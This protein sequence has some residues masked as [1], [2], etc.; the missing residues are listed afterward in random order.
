MAH[1][2]EILTAHPVIDGHN[3]LP[4]T[5][6]ESGAPPRDVDAYDLRRRTPGDTDLPRMRQGRVGAQFWSV[7]VPSTDDVKPLGLTR[8]Q[9]EQIDIALRIIE[10]YPEAMQLALTADDIERANRDG[11]IASLLGIEGAHTLENSLGTLRTYYRLGVRYMTL[12][13]YMNHDWA[14]SA[15]DARRHGG[16]TPF[17]KEVVRE[18]NR[19]GML[20]DLS[21]VSPDVM[22][23][24]LQ[25]S[26]APVIFSHSNALA[27]TDHPRNV[28]DDV[29]KRTG[30]GGGLVMV[31]FISM[32]SVTG[33]VHDRWRKGFARASAGAKPGDANF[34]AQY[35]LYTKQHPEPRATVAD[36][37]DHI[38][39][40][41]K[42]AGQDHVGIGSDFYGEG[43][44]MAAELEDTSSFPNLFAELVRRGWSDQALI[45]LARGNLLRVMREA[46]A[47]AA[48]IKRSR[49]ASFLTIEELDQGK[50]A[51]IY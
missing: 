11:R 37:A 26:Q 21:H 4:L 22:S 47:A 20:V 36:V 40:I 41:A 24:A 9:L 14:D 23:D 33:P 35:A 25:V 3:D 42:V 17:G 27:L 30:A 51:R 29:L 38:E 31:S 44:A 45:K 10:R 12:T 39:H 49:P 28:P 50:K 32:Y 43:G 16:L 5:V 13:H 46:E 48:R 1:A 34:D 18:M 19:L 15:T 7:W 2:L 8:I 6:R